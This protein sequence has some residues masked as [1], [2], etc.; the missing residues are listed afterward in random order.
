MNQRKEELLQKEGLELMTF[1]RRDIDTLRANVEAI[2]NDV[3]NTQRQ[4]RMLGVLD[5]LWQVV[6]ALGEKGGTEWPSRSKE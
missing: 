3:E 2:D 1:A 6:K 4:K 5:S